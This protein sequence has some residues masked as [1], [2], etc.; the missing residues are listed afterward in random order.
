MYQKKD[1]KNDPYLQ[2]KEDDKCMHIINVPC[3]KCE[4]IMKVAVLSC[5]NEQFLYGPEYFSEKDLK[6]ARENEAIIKNIF[7]EI[8]R[9]SYNANICKHCGT[10][11]GAFYLFQE[12]FV[13]KDELPSKL[14]RYKKLES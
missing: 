8:V 9:D 7:G 2:C 5:N 12:Y 10:F 11:V 13:Y 14:I 3:W 6:I 4:K 1:I